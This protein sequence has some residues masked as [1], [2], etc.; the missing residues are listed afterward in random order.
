LRPPDQRFSAELLEQAIRDTVDVVSAPLPDELGGGRVHWGDQLDV[1]HLDA[2]TRREVAGYLAKYATKST[3][4]AGGILHRVTEH[5]LDALP[6]RDHVRA[7]MRGAFELH[8]DTALADRRF[9]PC[10]HALGF[11]GHCLTKSRRYSTTFKA[12]RE[13]RE[14]HV[15]EQMLARSDDAAQRAI[16]DASER[17]ASFRYVGQGHITAADA[18]LASSAAARA[19]ENRRLA[20]EA[21][22]DH[23]RSRE[24]MRC[25]SPQR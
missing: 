14:R 24:E 2:G 20:R 19:R 23:H 9:G 25:E 22:S 7:Y 11:R 10:A 13:A 4:Q 12:L 1:R 3:E 17:I 8:R 21:L 5:Q 6:V 15:H 18:L 16:A